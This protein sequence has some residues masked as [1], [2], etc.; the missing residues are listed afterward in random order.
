MTGNGRLPCIALSSNFASFSGCDF[1]CKHDTCVTK[2][3]A[4]INS[5]DRD[6][7]PLVCIDQNFPTAPPKL[8]RL[9]GASG[10]K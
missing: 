6:V 5:I 9:R 10:L 7:V 2:M 1:Y 8:D 4:I 3:L